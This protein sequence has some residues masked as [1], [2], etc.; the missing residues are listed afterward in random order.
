[1]TSVSVV[2]GLIDVTLQWFFADARQ[3]VFLTRIY[4]AVGEAFEEYSR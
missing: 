1:M 4:Y 2:T 3:R